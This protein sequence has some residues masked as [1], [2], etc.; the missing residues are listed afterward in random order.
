MNL[1]QEGYVNQDNQKLERSILLL[2]IFMDK[3]EG[4][5]RFNPKNVSQNIQFSHF[6]RYLTI[7]ILLRP[8]NA[9]RD[10]RM[11]LIHPMGI[12]RKKVAD[13]F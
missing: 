4:I 9:K 11:N 6:N 12:F 2:M 1:L 7:N 5:F 8:E 3:F 13:A 10:V